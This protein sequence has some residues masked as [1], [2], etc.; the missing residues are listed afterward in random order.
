[1]TL[2]SRKKHG[3]ELVGPVKQN[4][5]R[6]QVQSGYDLSAFTINWDGKFAVCPEGK[7]STGWWSNTSATGREVI[8]TKFSR[9]DC[10]RCTVNALCTKNGAKNSRKL[11]LRPREEHELLIASRT[12]QRT[13]EW[14]QLYNKRAGI[15]ATFSQGVRSVGLRR[16]RYRG[17][18]KCHLQNVAIACA[19]NLQRLDD[20]WSGILPAPTR[21]S[22]FAQLGRWVM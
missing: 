12:E 14:K 1:L 10:A 18:A 11:S 17:L 5:H 3:I 6:S 2:E 7:R 22:A 16:S 13:P 21:N 19:I 4:W 15:E 9:T 8:S 20:Y